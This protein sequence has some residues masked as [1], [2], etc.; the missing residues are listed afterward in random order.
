[1][2]LVPD[3]LC[4]DR[5]EGALLDETSGVFLSPDYPAT[6]N[7]LA[8]VLGDFATKRERVGN[9]AARSLPLPFISRWQRTS[10]LSPVAES[11]AGITPHGF[12]TG[13]LAKSACEAAGKR[14]CK[15]EEWKKACRGQDNRMFPYGAQYEK[16][17]CNVNGLHHPGAM[18]HDNA[19][20]LH[21]DPRL[22]H[23]TVDGKRLLWPT[24]SA[25]R[26][27]SRWGDD[28][29]FD[30]VGNLDEWVDEKGGGFA[31]GFYARGT[32]AGCEALITA[33]PPGYLDYST[34]IRCCRD[35]AN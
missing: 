7:L 34:G 19:S 5:F 4:V 10:S 31:G 22:H 1:M 2:V 15:H 21:L 8:S 20:I 25:P 29:I 6:P 33:H 30:M 11:R 26:C 23:V 12:V 16:G 24:G 3:D 18:L 17:T 28:A 13:L 14:L 35:A 32:T 9:L 27:A